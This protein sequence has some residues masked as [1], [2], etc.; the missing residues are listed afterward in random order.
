[1][2]TT[3]P[4][5]HEFVVPAEVQRLEQYFGVWAS[6]S[7]VLRSAVLSASQMDLA[8][9]A[10]AYKA[11]GELGAFRMDGDAA[12]IDLVGSMTKYGSSMSMMS[13]GTVGVRKAIRNAVKDKSVKRIGLVI[14]SPGGTVEG[15]GDLAEE[16]RVAA[17]KKPVIAYV[18]DMCASAAYWVAS[19]ATRIVASPSAVIGSIGVYMI[20]YDESEAAEQQGVKTHVIRTAEFKGAGAPGT[21]VTDAQ[22][23]EWQRQCDEV[24]EL[25]GKAVMGGRGISAEEFERVATGSVWRADKAKRLKLIDDI[26]SYTQVFGKQAKSTLSVSPTGG[27]RVAI[28]TGRTLTMSETNDAMSVAEYIQ[29]LR[30]ACP[31]ASDSWL[32][33]QATASVDVD[34]AKAAHY[35]RLA[36]EASVTASELVTANTEIETLTQNVSALTEERDALSAKVTELTDELEKV[37]SG[38]DAISGEVAKPTDTSAKGRARALCAARMDSM[39]ETREA[40]WLAV[41]E[42]NPE[43]RE[44]LLREA[45]DR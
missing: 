29:T 6:E 26:K 9:H 2:K 43:L 8:Q 15:T 37:K 1:M 30:D 39:G 28:T 36:E 42:A 17:T 18:E 31:G 11:T 13:Y 25:F 24:H 4:E 19:Q 38:P 14:H 45:N 44:E 32:L 21:E 3:M 41:M 23:A 16:V 35:K 7:A 33:A 40:A 10:A 12:V 34:A 20:V 22:I 5:T 27:R